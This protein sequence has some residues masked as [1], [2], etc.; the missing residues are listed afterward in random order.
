MPVSKRRPRVPYCPSVCASRVFPGLGV[1]RCLFTLVIFPEEGTE[2]RRRQDSGDHAFPLAPTVHVFM[3][4]V[5]TEPEHR[6][7]SMR[8][9]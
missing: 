4:L 9:V 2:I 1:G 3:N 8:C 7:P 6:F 5:K